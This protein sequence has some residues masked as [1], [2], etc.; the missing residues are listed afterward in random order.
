[1]KNKK[2]PKRTIILAVILFAFLAIIT[3]AGGIGLTLAMIGFFG[4]F[5]SLVYIVV[6]LFKRKFNKKYLGLPLACFVAFLAGGMMLPTSSDSDQAAKNI[7]ETGGSAII[8][9]ETETVTESAKILLSDFNTVDEYLAAATKGNDQGSS[10]MVDA[11]GTLAK[12]DAET[13]TDDQLEDAVTFITNTYPEYFDSPETMEKTMYYGYLLDYAYE[14]DQDPY[15]ELGTD[16]Y[17]IVKY[18]YRG[19]ENPED[20]SVQE[21]LNQITKDLAALSIVTPYQESVEAE[22]SRQESI[23]ASK[24][25][26]EK[27][28]AKQESIQASKAAAE[29]EKAKQESIQASKEAAEK[30]NTEMVWIPATGSKYHNKPK[31]G[32]MDPSRARQVTRSEAEAAGYDPCKKC[33]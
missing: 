32:N 27:E 25:A 3:A 11:I 21:N 7:V 12:S 1:M 5:G 6:K 10:A 16:T 31:C 14:D 28:K 19:T 29:K 17:Q 24:A 18:V 13:A 9:T 15:S 4:F 22:E 20:Q 23:Q 2:V 26:A 30:E 33:Y 8:E